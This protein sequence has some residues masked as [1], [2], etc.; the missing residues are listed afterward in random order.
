M[1]V[2][3]NFRHYMSEPVG[4]EG[5]RIVI[6][7]HKHKLSLIRL[8]KYSMGEGKNNLTSSVFKLNDNFFNTLEYI[9]C[10]RIYTFQIFF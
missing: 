7:V 1:D 2:Y 6:A 9:R 4:N 10:M 3:A 8:I 5:I